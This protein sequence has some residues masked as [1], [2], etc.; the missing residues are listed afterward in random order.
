MRCDITLRK[1]WRT[2]LPLSTKVFPKG[3]DFNLVDIA[4]VHAI[5][6]ELFVLRAVG[7]FEGMKARA[8]RAARGSYG[9]AFKIAVE[10][11]RTVNDLGMSPHQ[12]Q[13]LA[14]ISF[15]AGLD[16]APEIAGPLYLED[17]LPWWRFAQGTKAFTSQ[18]YVDALRNCLALVSEPLVGPGSYW[19]QM[20]D[21]GWSALRVPDLEKI[22]HVTKTLSALGLDRQIH[23][24]HRGA[25]LNW[26]YL[27]TQF[28][29]SVGERLDFEFERLS[30]EAWRGELQGAVLLVEYK[31]GLH[32]DYAD[33][34]ELYPTGSPYRT[35][36]RHL[37]SY[38]PPAIQILGQILNGA[39]PRIMYAAY[40]GCAVPTVDILTP[41]LA[42]YL[43]NETVATDMMELVSTL[44]EKSATVA[45]G[46]LTLMP[47]TVHL[48]RYI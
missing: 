17:A 25:R 11:T 41:K 28:E 2:N 33:F 40:T 30:G 42:K 26:R 12:M 15:A 23:A 24:I 13:V 20:S 9:E 45:Q 47:K 38:S 46:Y 4:E 29:D 16:V 3:C 37:D 10:A 48:E 14:L 21:I 27:A 44:I 18:T 19:L 35:R 43:Q 32:F 6:M 39:T 34:D 5:A 8:E 31:D 36:L 22:G 7:D 1:N